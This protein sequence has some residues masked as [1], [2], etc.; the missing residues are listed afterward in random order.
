MPFKPKLV[1]ALLDTEESTDKAL[2]TIEELQKMLIEY[3]K[4]IE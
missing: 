1:S 2:T 4:S 3:K